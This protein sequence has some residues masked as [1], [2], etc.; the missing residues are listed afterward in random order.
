MSSPA[1]PSVDG[2]DSPPVSIQDE[3]TSPTND[4]LIPKRLAMSAEKQNA[5]PFTIKASS[6]MLTDVKAKMPSFI[7][8]LKEVDKQLGKSSIHKSSCNAIMTAV[9][10]MKLQAFTKHSAKVSTKDVQT[11]RDRDT[12]LVSTIISTPDSLLDAQTELL[13]RSTIPSCSWQS[14]T[15]L[16]RTNPNGSVEMINVLTQ[17]DWLNK[18]ALLSSTSLMWVAHNAEILAQDGLSVKF[19]CSVLLQLL[20]NSC[21]SDLRDKITTN[22]D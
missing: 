5:T 8:E 1:T 18:W 22:I 12:K 11:I 16:I 15:R 7:G 6:T 9:A 20:L 4:P 10:T 19:S 14:I 13:M 3:N 21:S 17:Y 2:L